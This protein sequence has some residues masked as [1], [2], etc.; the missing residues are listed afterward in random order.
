M[1]TLVLCKNLVKA[2]IL[3]KVDV[4]FVTI[5]HQFLKVKLSAIGSPESYERGF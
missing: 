3:V 5:A 2:T 1:W 4:L